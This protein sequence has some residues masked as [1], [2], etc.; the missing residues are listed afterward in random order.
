LLGRALT[1]LRRQAA[2]G[3]IHTIDALLG[4]AMAQQQQ[5]AFA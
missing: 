3:V 1:A 5:L 2:L 4:N